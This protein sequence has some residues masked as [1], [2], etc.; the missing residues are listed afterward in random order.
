MP[1]SPPAYHLAGRL[2]SQLGCQLG[3]GAGGLAGRLANLLTGPLSGRPDN[4]CDSRLAASWPPGQL[5]LGLQRPPVRKFQQAV[6]IF[7]QSYNMQNMFA[8]LYVSGVVVYAG[9]TGCLL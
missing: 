6:K 7:S 3:S 2:A 4:R 8:V 1:S 9:L 5:P